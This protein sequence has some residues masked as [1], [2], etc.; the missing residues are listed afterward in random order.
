MTTDSDTRAPRGRG[1]GGPPP[2]RRS[3]REAAPR[4]LPVIQKAG[5][6]PCFECAKCC[7]YVAVEI[8][9][10]TVNKDYDH[11][12]WY[13]YHQG[14]KVFV[15]W[16]G[17]WFISFETRCQ[18]LTPA[19]MCGI[20]ERRPGICKDFD[21]RECEQTIRD[22]APDKHLFE[23]AEQFMGWLEKQRPKAY[24]RYQAFLDRKHGTDEEPELMRLQAP[25]R[26]RR[27]AKR[28]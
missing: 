17:D 14:V 4:L 16:E 1:P 24:A 18:H 13:L 27:K 28:G 23:T 15:D 25:G 10:P 22:E 6:H 19:G 9:A 26:G 3:A 12:V 7:H 5:D 2:P 11:I 20:Y 8:D 21:W